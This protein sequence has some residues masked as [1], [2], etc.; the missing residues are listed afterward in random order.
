MP[1]AVQ[2]IRVQAERILFDASVVLDNQHFVYISGDHGSGWINKDV[3]YLEP[4][5]V[6]TLAEM[7][8]QLLS[9]VEADVVCGP[10]TGGLVISQ[11]LAYHMKLKSI[12]AEHEVKM[13]DGDHSMRPPFVLKRHYDKVA[14]G[15]RVIVVDDIINTG[16]SIIQTMAAVK[17]AGGI[18]VCA[19]TICDRG[20]VDVAHID[21]PQMVALTEIKI[22]SWPADTCRLCTDG[23]P[24]NVEYAHGKDYMQ[25]LQADP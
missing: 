8:A 4:G 1:S 22:P 19:A 21:A 25:L 3:L 10:A 12:F 24:I 18:V 11:W 6:S 14:A 7:L 2:D 23:I 5:R 16:H 15:Q 17:R 13:V 20:N 9:G